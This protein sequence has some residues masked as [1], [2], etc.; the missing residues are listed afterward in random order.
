MTKAQRG[1]LAASLR[2]HMLYAAPALFSGLVL[3]ASEVNIVDS[4]Y[5][6]TV[7]NLQRLHQRTPRGFAFLLAG[8]L[9][10]RAA[11]HCRQLS[12]F[13]MVCHLHGDPLQEMAIMF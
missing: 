9:P 13:L 10:G 5:K 12:L 11:L 2:V 6:N 1:N 3:G 8:C 4:S 7:Q